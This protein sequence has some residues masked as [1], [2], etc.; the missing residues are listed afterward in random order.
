MD[1]ELVPTTAE[2][3]I[4]VID[5]VYLYGDQG[6]EISAVE[7]LLDITTNAA[8]N[9]LKMGVQLEILKYDTAATR[10]INQS[11]FTKFLISSD[12]NQKAAFFRLFLEDYNPYAFFKQRLAILSQVD[13]AAE[14]TKV[15]FSLASHREDIKSTLVNLGQYAKSIES[16]GAGL[17]KISGFEPGNLSN[18]SEMEHLVSSIENAKLHVIDYLGDNVVSFLRDTDCIQNFAESVIHLKSHGNDLR[19]VIVFS[20]N[21]IETFLTKIADMAS[22]NIVGADGVNAKVERLK[23]DGKINKKYYNISKYIGHVRNAADH[24]LDSEISDEWRI[25]SETAHNYM[26]VALSFAKHYYE[27]FSGEYTV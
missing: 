7:N 10:F 1:F 18:Y 4:S 27:S 20:A 8:E 15:F 2:L 25:S 6:V 5:A 12:Q 14:Q 22:V 24:G 16:E 23:N 17:Y 21:A 26:K 9:A 19:A 13:A 3:I 11:K